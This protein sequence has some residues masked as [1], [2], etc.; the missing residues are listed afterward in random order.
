MSAEAFISEKD[1]RKRYEYS[2]KNILGEGG[3]AQVYK[4]FDKQLQEFVAL[5]IYYRSETGK[6]DVIHEMKDSRKYSH[7]NIIRVYDAYNVRFE[8]Q[9]RYTIAQVGILEYANGGNLNDFIE[10]NISESQFTKVIIEILT[11]LEYLHNKKNVIHRD[12]SPENILMFREG[13]EW[14]PKLAD[15]GIS[16]KINVPSNSKDIQK[17]AQLVGKIGYMAP[18]QFY[19]KKFGINGAIDTNVDLWAFG[20]VLYELFLH[21]MPFDYDNTGNP[22]SL[23]NS[24]TQ[25]PLP[26]D[27]RKIP[28]TYQKVIRK[29]LV[30]K[31]TDRVKDANQLILQLN[32]Q[33][34]EISARKLRKRKKLSIFSN[35]KVLKSIPLALLIISILLFSIYGI[36][37]FQGRN[38]HITNLRKQFNSADYM[39]VIQYIENKLPEKY[40]RDS[41]IIELKLKAIDSILYGRS[42]SV[43]PSSQSSDKKPDSNQEVAAAIDENPKNTK[44][45]VILNSKIVKEK[46]PSPAA[47]IS[48]SRKVSKDTRNNK[49]KKFEDYLNNLPEENIYKIDANYS[50]PTYLDLRNLYITDKETIISLKFNE[51]AASLDVSFYLVSPG[52]DEALLLEY[53]NKEYKLKQ[54]IGLKVESDI[55]LSDLTDKTFY[56]VFEKLPVEFDCN[57]LNLIDNTTSNYPL[58]Y[59]DIFCE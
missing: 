53:Q 36:Y 7:P 49:G 9:G 12:I 30:K 4:A 40:S 41:I 13:N 47:S 32:K 39:R 45:E 50:I 55:V 14:I 25:D 6:Y 19:P 17:T 16:K 59:F 52:N 28:E 8:T 43:S 46:E 54:V 5:K 3:F 21:K 33:T 29:C 57:S 31:A 10:A 51:I 34:S 24:I 37:I 44:E 23:I 18:E 11:A 48:E 42:L 35:K 58:N 1:F 38:R 22:L 26:K 27:V 2:E 56:L 15:F 20:I